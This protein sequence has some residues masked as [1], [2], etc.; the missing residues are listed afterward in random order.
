MKLGKNED[1][2]EGHRILKTSPGSRWGWTTQYLYKECST[3][4]L[5]YS[6]PIPQEI[7]QLSI[8]Q[9]TMI[10][11][12]CSSLTSLVQSFMGKGALLRSPSTPSSY[13]FTVFSGGDSAINDLPIQ[14]TLLNFWKGKKLVCH[15]H[16]QF[17]FICFFTF[18]THTTAVHFPFFLC[19]STKLHRWILQPTPFT[20]ASTTNSNMWRKNLWYWYNTKSSHHT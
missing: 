3:A 13:S 20:N 1:Y 7:F 4:A 9:V 2:G 5:F 17:H 19:W 11:E 8:C 10:T 16:G 14:K 6:N 12:V 18:C 15:S